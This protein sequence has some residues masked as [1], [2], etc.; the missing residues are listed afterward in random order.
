VEQIRGERLQSQIAGLRKRESQS[1]SSGAEIRSPRR[2]SLVSRFARAEILLIKFLAKRMSQK[3][4]IHFAHANG[5]PAGTYTKLFSHLADG[6]EIGYLERHGHN[7]QFPV[8]DNWN[9]LRDELR[10]E[11]ER[12]YEE[13]IIGVGHSLGGVLHFLVAVEA[14]ALYRQIILLDAPVI[15]RLSSHGL[16]ILKSTRLIDRYS[17][18]QMTRYRRNLWESKEAA[19]D[20]FRRKPKFAAFDPQVL[21]D[22]IDYGTVETEKGFELFFSPRTE[23]KIYRTIPHHLPSLRGKLKVPSAYIGGTRSREGAL[24]RLS[25][26]KKHFPIDFYQIEGSHL[27]PFEKPEATAELLKKIVK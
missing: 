22:Y 12:R 19:L 14:P 8:T 23:A 5:F 15:S 26:M 11:I 21:R 17:P 9:A 20:Y 16:R 4:V 10:A 7:P 24:A 27:F 1:R 3:P 2:T 13:K 6:F 18:S 25:F